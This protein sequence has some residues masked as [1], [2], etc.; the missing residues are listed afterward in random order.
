M[1]RD[2]GHFYRPGNDVGSRESEG[3]EGSA[4]ADSVEEDLDVPAF[5]RSH[6]SE[7]EGS[8]DI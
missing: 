2:A 4:M 6:D 1:P 7:P 3:G 8:N 5:L